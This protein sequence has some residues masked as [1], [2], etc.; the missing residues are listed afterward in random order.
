MDKDE[1]LFDIFLFYYSI[2]LNKYVPIIICSYFII[3]E[4]EASTLNFLHT[5]MN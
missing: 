5:S 3:I 1:K 4:V 2:C